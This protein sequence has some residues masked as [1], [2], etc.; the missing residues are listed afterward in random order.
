MS[1]D[2][3][4]PHVLIVGGGLGGLML[5]A[6][7]EKAAVPYLIFERATIVKPLGSALSLGSQL[8]PLLEQLGIKD[9]LIAQ[10]KRANTSKAMTESGETI[11][12]MDYSTMEEFGGYSKYVFS[13][14]L[15]YN[16]LLSLVPPEKILFGKRV[17]NIS[18]DK[19]KVTVQTA[20][21]SEYTGDILVGADGAYS[22][23]R[24][25]LYERLKQEGG[26]PRSDQEDLPFGCT[27]LVGQTDPLDPE[28]Y[29]ELKD[30]DCHF[31]GT[32]GDDQPYTWTLFSTAS[33]TVC[34]MV[35]HHLDTVSTKLAHE[36]RF[37]QSE[38]SEWGSYA[39]Q[40][41]CDETRDFPIPFGKE[42]LT[43]GDLYDK[44]PKDLIAKVMLEEKVFKTWHHGRT[45]LLGDGA[46]AAMQDALALANLIYA[47]P[48][49]SSAD[50]EK[51]FKEYQE[52]RYDPAVAAFKSSQMLS[53]IMNRGIEGKIAV[54]VS[55]NMPLFLWKKF[56]RKLVLNR[57]QAGFLPPADDRGTAPPNVSPS[58]EKARLVFERRA[59]GAA[60]GSATV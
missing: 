44:T 17:L 31:V 58:S 4:K 8:L 53:K 14:P 2:L 33:F 9:T 3:A 12:T 16:I 40:T 55:Q 19:D 11:L 50:I 25:R 22:A 38:N 54:M 26:L 51:A 35:M 27:C 21:N 29:P 45:V 28:E 20:D 52:E 1:A 48:D 5:G 13:R 6:L 47:L 57:P 24:Q 43:L 46:I 10:G 60:T 56:V 7:L 59:A 15:L 36:Q 39:A 49:N 34:W 42:K 32:L 18:E 41:M 23:V 37:R 30:P